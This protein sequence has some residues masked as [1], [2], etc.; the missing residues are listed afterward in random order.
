MKCAKLEKRITNNSTTPNS[1]GMD[2]LSHRRSIKHH[3]KASGTLAPCA[4]G[5]FPGLGKKGEGWT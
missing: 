2:R 1:F 4:A 5:A 3:A